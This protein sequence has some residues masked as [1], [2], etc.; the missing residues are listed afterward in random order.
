[1]GKL[2]AIMKKNNDE[3]T[4]M[5]VESIDSISDISEVI[6]EGPIN[7]WRIRTN[8]DVCLVDH[9]PLDVVE[10]IGYNPDLNAESRLYVCRKL[11]LDTIK[12]EVLEKD[13]LTNKHDSFRFHKQFNDETWQKGYHKNF[14]VQFIN[15]RISAEHS[16]IASNF[17]ISLTPHFGDATRA[18]ANSSSLTKRNEKVLE[19]VL[20]SPPPHLTPY[21][22]RHIPK[23]S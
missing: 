7:L 12:P 2:F 10:V 14:I 13:K 20:D 8:I 3:D 15:N 1:M 9:V 19:A 17:H 6:F 16:D 11:L 5:T 23:V 4:I 18:S 22:T 21:I